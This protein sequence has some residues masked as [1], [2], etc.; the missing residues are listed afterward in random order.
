[1]LF[2]GLP[3]LGHL[4]YLEREIFCTGFFPPRDLAISNYK[5]YHIPATAKNRKIQFLVGMRLG[6]NATAMVPN[7]TAAIQQEPPTK[8]LFEAI[9]EL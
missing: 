4:R 3:R 9:L 8:K 7:A 6:L 5:L 1:M 2:L